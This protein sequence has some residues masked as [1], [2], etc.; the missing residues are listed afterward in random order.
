MRFKKM[1]ASRFLLLQRRF[2]SATSAKIDDPN[3]CS[4]L[5]LS[6]VTFVK[7][8]K[9]EVLE[10]SSISGAFDIFIMYL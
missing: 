5:T 1:C 8:Y 6:D 4:P 10:V 3:M 9:I 7:K 2:S